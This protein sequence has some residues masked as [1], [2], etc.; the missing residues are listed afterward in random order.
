MICGF[1]ILNW[2]YWAFFLPL[3]DDSGL[4]LKVKLSQPKAEEETTTPVG[5][6]LPVGP[7]CKSSLSK[8]HYRIGNLTFKSTVNFTNF[9]TA[10]FKYS[11]GDGHTQTEIQQSNVSTVKHYYSHG[12][13]YEYYVDALVVLEDNAAAVHS[14]H[15]SS[16]KV[17]GK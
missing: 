10:Y 1:V 5:P 17:Y 11:F 12:G 16:T 15:K 2:L 9:T 14:H 13:T 6:G 4:S 8:R 7:V 3:L